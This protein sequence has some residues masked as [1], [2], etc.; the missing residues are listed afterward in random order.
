MAKKEFQHLPVKLLRGDELF[1][2]NKGLSYGFTI[3]DFWR[4][5]YSNIYDNTGDI[6]EFIVAMALGINQSYKKY[7]WTLYDIDYKGYRIEVKATQ[8]FQIWEKNGKISKQKR[9]NIGKSH[10]TEGDVTSPRI[11]NNDIYVLCLN[12][13]ET[14]ETSDPR[15][16]DNW[17]FWVI[18][19]KVIDYECGEKKTISLQK[20]KSLCETKDGVTF[21]NLK[22]AIEKYTKS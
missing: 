1:K 5:M 10:S 2:N 21:E 18:P 14:Y 19:T 15:N 11:R 20:V 8:Y 7:G 16:L 22:E 6:A 3:H 17:L 12:K 13:G 4:F 9:F